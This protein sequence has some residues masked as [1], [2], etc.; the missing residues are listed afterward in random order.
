M[1]SCVPDK[2]RVY[3]I[4]LFTTPSAL[5]DNSAFWGNSQDQLGYAI[6]GHILLGVGHFGCSETLVC[7]KGSSTG[8][9]HNGPSNIIKN[10]VF[11]R[12]LTGAIF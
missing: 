1:L 8:G 4:G 9:S 2:S 5:E 7:K 11:A 12:T 10:N 6:E 3:T